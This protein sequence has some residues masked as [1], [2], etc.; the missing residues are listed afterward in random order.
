MSILN[1]ENVRFRNIFSYGR[2]LQEVPLLRGVNVVMGI[3]HE[4]GR[5]NAA[6]KSSFLRTLPFALFGK[7]HKNPIKKENIVNWKNRRNCEVYLDTK[8]NETTYTFHRGLRPDTL[9]V[10]ENGRRIP[11]PSDIRTFQK[12]IEKEILGFDFQ[13]FMSL[14]HTNLNDL[15]PIL[16]MDSIRKRQFL[17]AVFNLEYFTEAANSAN[18]KMKTTADKVYTFKTSIEFAN[19]AIDEL[20]KQNITLR[21]KL[22][23]I[24]SSEREL[25]AE[26]EK[27]NELKKQK[28]ETSLGELERRS[29]QHKNKIDMLLKEIMEKSKQENTALKETKSR[30]VSEI[31]SLDIELAETKTELKNSDSR[32]KDLEGKNICPLC[33]TEINSVSILE[34]IQETCR[35]LQ[36][37]LDELKEARKIREKELKE[38]EN[39][40]EEEEEARKAEMRTKER[41]MKKLNNEFSDLGKNI[42]VTKQLDKKIQEVENTIKVLE[43]RTSHEVKARTD[44]MIMEQENTEKV[45]ELNKETRATRVKITQLESIM[46]YLEL[47]KVLCKDENAKQYAISAHIPFVN[48]RTNKYLSDGGMSFYVKFDNWLEAEIKGPGIYNCAYENLSGGEMRSVDLALQFAFLDVARIQ[49]AI[50][51]DIAVV[52]E[53]L[54]SSIDAVGLTDILHIIKA[55]Q[56]EDQSKIFLITHRPEVDTIEA[57]NVYLVEK[58]DGFSSVRKV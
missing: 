37:S 47:I 41:E 30:L 8:K 24:A 34:K 28:E 55:K 33:E 48:E 29:E 27:L 42:E 44:L 22:G 38:T 1:F 5:S 53:M 54:D 50:F 26:K 51:P 43:E 6:G 46:D 36:T 49:T 12:T 45:N 9:E 56:V 16:Q 57:D 3:D 13:T 25:E 35:G 18:E 10:F 2:R 19:K 17:S 21:L 58:R 32:K 15:T 40:Y 23:N 14:V 52:D 7:T 31:H 11:T 4:K 39:R 20:E